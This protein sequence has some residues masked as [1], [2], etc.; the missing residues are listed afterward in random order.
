MALSWVPM[1][2]GISFNLQS[3]KA[4]NCPID[5]ST[6]SLDPV[7]VYM[8]PGAECFDTSGS[9]YEALTFELSISR[10]GDAHLHRTPAQTDAT[11]PCR[12][13]RSLIEA[14]PP[15]LIEGFSS[16]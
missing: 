7:V 12:R 16:R 8:V 15:S 9:R 3:G 13:Y 10:V 5:S 14:P 1:R 6:R 2:S 11:G 4:G